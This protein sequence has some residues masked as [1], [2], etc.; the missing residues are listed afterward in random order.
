LIEVYNVNDDDERG[1]LL[2]DYPIPTL[3]TSL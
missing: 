3:L 2:S 1:S